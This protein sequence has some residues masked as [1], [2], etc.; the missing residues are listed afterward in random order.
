MANFRGA[1]DFREILP[2][3]PATQRDQD[4]LLISGFRD[5][6]YDADL[7]ELL[8]RR[9]RIVSVRSYLASNNENRQ[10]S[11]GISSVVMQN[12]HNTQH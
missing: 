12:V 4:I 6:F 10:K 8:R 1:R 9:G 2:Q 5:T 3:V 11:L 7:I